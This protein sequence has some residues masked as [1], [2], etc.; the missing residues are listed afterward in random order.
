VQQRRELSSARYGSIEIN[1][2]YEAPIGV[3]VN[4]LSFGHCRA[5]FEVVARSTGEHDYL[6]GMRLFGKERA[7]PL[8]PEV[9]ALNELIVEDNRAR[10]VFGE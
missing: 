3:L 2:S 9:V 10:Q 6:K 1:G 5:R 7:E 8:H 4:G